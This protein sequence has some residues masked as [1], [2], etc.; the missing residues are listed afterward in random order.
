MT[1]VLLDDG[2]I[3]YFIQQPHSRAVADDM[4]PG[5]TETDPGSPIVLA[6]RELETI[7]GFPV[8]ALTSFV[9]SRV[10]PMQYITIKSQSASLRILLVWEKRLVSLATVLAMEPD[11]LLLDEPLTGLDTDTSSNIKSIISKLDQSYI[12]I[13]HDIDFLSLATN[14]ICTIQ[15]G[16]I[17][18]EDKAQIHVHRHVHPHGGYPHKHT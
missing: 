7:T 13:S 11:V 6:T 16:K 8:I 3:A 12:V 5:W 14:R 17:I 2:Y 4:W 10:N 15:D 1:Q 9:N 18:D